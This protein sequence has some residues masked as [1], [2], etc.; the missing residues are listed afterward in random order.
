MVL[1]WEFGESELLFRVQ[2]YMDVVKDNLLQCRSDV[3]FGI[4][5]AFARE[6][7]A[8]PFPQR[9]LFIKEWPEISTAQPRN[10]PQSSSVLLGPTGMRASPVP[11]KAP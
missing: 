9:E 5:D 11:N 3:N 2:Y 6:K 10:E 7:I 1:L 8:I 4:W